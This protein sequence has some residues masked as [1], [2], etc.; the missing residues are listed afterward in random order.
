MAK[1]QVRSG[2]EAR[3]PKKEKVKAPASIKHSPTNAAL[4]KNQKG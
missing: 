3:K 2:K 1:G 4:N